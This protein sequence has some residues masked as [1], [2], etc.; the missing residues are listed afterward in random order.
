MSLTEYY[1]PHY[2]A[3]RKRF[4]DVA[5]GFH[6]TVQSHPLPG[7]GPD[8][9]S[10]LMDVATLGDPDARRVVIVSSGLHGVE[11]FL[12]SAIQLAWMSRQGPNWTP[13]AGVRVV[14]VHA[15]NPFGFAWRRRWNEN[16]VDLNRNFLDD[17]TFLQ[18]DPRYI[19]S[20]DAYARYK[21]FLNPTSAPSRWEPYSIKAIAHIMRAG[22]LASA[23]ARKRDE[24]L[25]RVPFKAMWKLGIL[26]LQKTLPVGQYEHP[27]GLFYGGSQAEASV[28]LVRECLP[29]WVGAGS[30]VMHIDFHSGLGSYGD[31]RML[32]VDDAGSELEQQANATFGASVVEAAGGDTGY[33]ARG[34]MASHLRDRL[35]RCRYQC[36]TAEFGTYPGMRVLG[37]LRAENRAHHHDRPGTASYRR[38][39]QQI[40]EAFCPADPRWREN[41]VASGLEIVRQAIK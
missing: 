25:S 37:A 36:L 22:F 18:S 35:P 32:L 30:D 21:S 4:L 3:A 1:S 7:R 20:R 31:Y 16:N 14:M 13:P 5:V 23:Q 12:G 17:R 19:E 29:A 11:G 40:S 27:R 2:A 8:G 41:V 15:I 9:E 39:K 28:Q 10:L 26:E 38:A 6:A 33:N 34:Q 24:T